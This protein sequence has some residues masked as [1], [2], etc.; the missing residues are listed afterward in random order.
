M[1]RRLPAGDRDLLLD[2]CLLPQAV[3]GEAQALVRDAMWP[4][5]GNEQGLA[6]PSH[7]A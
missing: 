1:H 7:A 6:A 5:P 2:Q 3:G 4:E